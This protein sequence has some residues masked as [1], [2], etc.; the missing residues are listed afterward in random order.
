MGFMRGLKPRRSPTAIAK[1]EAAAFRADAIEM[2]DMDKD[3]I[4]ETSD[5]DNHG[6]SE[7]KKAP[8]GGMKNYFVRTWSLSKSNC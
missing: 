1:A 6:A 2:V 4:T 8:E 3:I 7:S 5:T